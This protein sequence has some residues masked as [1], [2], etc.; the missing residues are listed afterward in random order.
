MKKMCVMFFTIITC[1]TFSITTINAVDVSQTPSDV[2]GKQTLSYSLNYIGGEKP[3]TENG[4]T[5]YHS[6]NIVELSIKL[7][8]NSYSTLAYN[9]LKFDD[10]LVDL[11][12]SFREI[13]QTIDTTLYDDSWSLNVMKY[14]KK[15]NEIL[16]VGAAD[17]TNYGANISGGTVAKV[18][19]KVKETPE[20]T[21]GTIIN[22]NNTYQIIA[23]VNGKGEYTHIGYQNTFETQ[24]VNAPTISITA[25]KKQTQ[26]NNSNNNTGEKPAGS[27]VGDIITNKEIL[28]NIINNNFSP[29]LQAQIEAITS[30]YMYSFNTSSNH[31]NG[32]NT[33]DSIIADLLKDKNDRVDSNGKYKSYSF[34]NTPSDKLVDNPSSDSQSIIPFIF[35]ILSILVLIGTLCYDSLE[36]Y[37]LKERLRS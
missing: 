23:T 6:G 17:D 29:E 1:L 4:V 24:F 36:N 19:F 21:E 8:A 11:Y 18:K 28:D 32:V 10:S 34:E 35:I 16:I 14:D 30:M 5:Y 25:S 2:I 33:Y 3:Y 20:T 37:K 26:N 9:I 31:L 22:F 27:G 13:T 7:P 12:S 15:N